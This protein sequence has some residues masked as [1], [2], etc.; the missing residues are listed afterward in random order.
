MLDKLIIH[1][2]DCKSGS[3]SI[4]AILFQKAWT[5]SSHTILYPGNFNHTRLAKCLIE[6]G[7]SLIKAKLF[8]NIKKELLA[9]DA[10]VGVLSAEAFEF[11]DPFRLKEAIEIYWP[12]FK[13]N[14]QF[15][16]Y[17]RPHANRFLAA[18]SER[19]KKGG[20]TDSLRQFEE[21][22]E[23]RKLL[24]YA[25]RIRQWKQA[26]GESYHVKPMKLE[27]LKGQDV[28]YDFFHFALGD[29]DFEFTSSTRLNE[30]TSL[31]DLSILRYIHQKIAKGR[32]PSSIGA[33][34]RL[35]RHLSQ[36]MCE[37]PTSN[38]MKLQLYKKLAAK[39]LDTYLKDAQEIDSL[40]FNGSSLESALQ[41]SLE[42]A[43][44]E[45]QSLDIRSYYSQES[46]RIID[47]WLEL[48]YRMM[49]AN[50]AVFT[51]L[52]KPPSKSNS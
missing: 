2:G 29:D 4:Q 5:S 38:P 32:R 43:L 17:I 48:N 26:F 11:V 20:F 51:R 10:S 21:V 12:E 16:S 22:C 6:N 44:E 46:I 9:S 30:S 36:I 25:P 7:S 50:P 3:T 24:M 14:I 28:V 52:A 31:P 35:G 42:K 33:Y 47:C 39:M 19:V 15:I 8:N 37:N 49:M 41:L 34:T 23:Q 18:F 1:L 45:P 27:D 40:Y 13:S